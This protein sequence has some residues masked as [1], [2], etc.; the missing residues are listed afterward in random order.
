MQNQTETGTSKNFN[1]PDETRPFI[2]HGHLDLLKFEGNAIIGK[3]V[4]E[5]GWKWSTD[6]K[7]IA[8]TKS[9][10]AAH[11]GYCVEGSMRIA[12]DNG[13][14]FTIKPGDAFQIPPGHD[15][16]VE[17]DRNCVLID[18]SGY[19]HYAENKASH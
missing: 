15:A 4:F 7:P 19:E 16:W 1:L 12:M 2:G 10:E 5:P 11:T 17:G 9:C 6:V 3:G 8:G 14:E 18:V 13:R